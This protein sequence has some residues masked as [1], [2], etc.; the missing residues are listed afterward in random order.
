MLEGLRE[1][2][3]DGAPAHERGRVVGFNDLPAQYLLERPWGA[4][5]RAGGDFVDARCV[6]V[7]PFALEAFAKPARP[8]A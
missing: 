8:G 5:V 2:R 7:V 3:V 1:E 4:N 6:G